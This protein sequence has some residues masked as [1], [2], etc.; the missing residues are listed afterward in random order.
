MKQSFTFKE[1]NE[2]KTVNL[3]L[4]MPRSIY[5]YSVS[6][7]LRSRYSSSV[8]TIF[9]HG[10]ILLQI[11]TFI[12]IG[13]SQAIILYYLNES[14]PYFKDSSFCQ[15]M[16]QPLLLLCFIGVFLASLL[17][18]LYDISIEIF[19]VLSSKRYTVRN[20]D[21]KDNIDIIQ[22]K[23]R[24]ITKLLIAYII[25]YEFAIWVFVLIIGVRYILTTQ[26]TGNIVQAAVAIVYINEIDN[27]AIFLY[28]EQHEIFDIPYFNNV[29]STSR[30]RYEGHIV[31]PWRQLYKYFGVPMIILVS[32]A[33]IYL[34]QYRYCS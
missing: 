4:P 3:W 16:H 10:D 31:T 29:V 8:K 34:N 7:L 5:G 26:G 11:F 25:L 15:N 19:T 9:D 30:D 32:L 2:L 20:N 18:S 1:L 13:S 28:P 23:I 22:I 12:A 6:Y 17:P 21:N 33:I 27:M 14:L 24:F